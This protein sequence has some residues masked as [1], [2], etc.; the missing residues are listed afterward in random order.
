MSQKKRNGLVIL[1]IL[2]AIL[3]VL[4]LMFFLTFD[5]NSNKIDTNT[6][7]F[8]LNSTP[9]NFTFSTNNGDAKIIPSF[10]EYIGVIYVEGTIQEKNKY[11]DH[12]FLLNTIYKLKKDKKNLG[13]MVFIDSPGGT[14]YHSDELYLTLREYSKAGKPVWAYMGSMACSGGYYI[15]CGAEKIICNR[16]CLTGSIG[17][18]AGQSVDLTELMARYGIKMTTITAGKNKNM[19]NLDSPMTEEHKAIMQSIADEAYEQFTGIVAGSRGLTLA[20]TKELADGRIY[21]AK[22]ALENG[23]VDHIAS[24][25]SALENFKIHLSENEKDVQI[26]YFQQKQNSSFSDFFMEKIKEI[27]PKSEFESIKNAVNQIALP[28]D[29]DFPAYYFKH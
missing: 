5:I 2:I 4:A 29:L 25:D 8:E 26:K 20:K 16:N 14:V 19:L 15:A 23:L 13:L 22:Q 12:N 18:I 27:Q 10:S 17:V 9:F 7:T 24:F 11:Y 6:D 28:E 1:L 21:T 3:I